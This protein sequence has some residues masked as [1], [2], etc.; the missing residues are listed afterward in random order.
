MNADVLSKSERAR[1][2]RTF[3]AMNERGVATTFVP[4]RDAALRTVLEMI[5]R[6][7]AVAHGTSITLIQI[8]LVDYLKQPG[9]GCR[10]MNQ[11]WTAEND[12]TNRWKLRGKLSLES[13]YYLGGIQAICE[14]GEAIGAD[15]SGS[16]QAFFIFGPPHVIWVA[17]INK[18]VPTVE[19]GIRRLREVALPLEDK[20]MKDTGAPG[21]FVGKMVIYERERPGRISLVLVGEELGY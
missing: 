13:D 7:S 3:A 12:V 20:R 2:E 14:T 5:P 9:S 6:G 1:V 17:G 16:R 18:L 15:A 19:D 11:E 10:Y 8:G 21:S 4:D